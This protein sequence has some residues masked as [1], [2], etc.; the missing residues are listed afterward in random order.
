MAPP[1][2]LDDDDDNDN[3]IGDVDGVP[4]MAFDVDGNGVA[5]FQDPLNDT[6]GD[7]SP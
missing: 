6:D 4:S 1:A 3:Q 2:Y 5:E 7:G